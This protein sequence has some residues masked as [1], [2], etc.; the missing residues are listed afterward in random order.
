M[1]DIRALQLATELVYLALGVAAAL[2]AARR[3]EQARVDVALLFGALALLA[4][5]QEVRHASI[6]DAV[7]VSRVAALLVLS[8]PY[9]L[10]RLVDDVREVSPAAPPATLATFALFAVGL[11][12]VPE[13]LPPGFGLAVA[14]FV[15]LGILYAA[16]AFASRARETRGVMCR[17]MWSAAIAA[18]L[19]GAIVPFGLWGVFDPGLASVLNLLAQLVALLSALLFYVAFFPPSVLRRIWRLSELFTYLRGTRWNP[20]TQHLDAETSRRGGSPD[21][22]AL[23]ELCLH[24]AAA[25]GGRRAV[26]AVRD[27]ASGDLFLWGAPSARLSAADGLLGS[28]LRTGKPVFA[29]L[30]DPSQLAPIMRAV[31]P[32]RR[33]PR[34]ALLAPVVVQSEPLGVLAVFGDKRSVFVDDDLDVVAFFSVEVAAILLERQHREAAQEL[35]ALRHADRLKDEFMAVVS[36]E[37]R[38][39]LT[40]ITGYSD[41]LLRKLSGPLNER[42]ERQVSSTRDAARRL[43]ALINDLLD[44]SKLQAGALQLSLQ[45][46]AL[47]DVV[48]RSVAETRAIAATKRIALETTPLEPELPLVMADEQ[49]LQQILVNLI[50]NAVKF[51][52]ERG[53]IVVEAWS[54]HVEAGSHVALAVKDTGMGIAPYDLPRIWE[55]FYQADSSSTREYG[56]AGLGLSIVK[57]LVELHGG[58]VEVTSPGLGQGSTFTVRLPAALPSRAG[59]EM[60]ANPPEPEV[61]ARAAGPREQGEARAERDRPLVL[62]VEDDPDIAAVLRTYLEDDGYS[63]V[64]M[65]DGYR[66]LAFAEAQHPFAIMLDVML[67]RLDGWSVLNRL[68]RNPRTANV[69]VIV[70]SIVDNR[71]YGILLGA[72]DYLVKPVDQERMRQVL[73]RVVDHHPSGPASLL[74]VDDDPAVRAMLADAFADEGWTIRNAPDGRSALQAVEESL[75][76]A[77][78][79]DL[80]M[81]GVDGFEVL[82][83]LRSRKETRDLPVLVLTARELTDDDRSRLAG[84]AQQVVLKQA[85]RIDSLREAIR[86]ALAERRRDI[87]RVDRA[88]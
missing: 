34:T 75:P 12:L 36:H 83:A 6:V 11:L 39:P 13:P 61:V 52:P 5:V 50:A 14:T 4:A 59:G 46:V 62:V 84:A 58:S 67:P 48:V 30:D 78:L 19:L 86:A 21:S 56:G 65:S 45:P 79:L 37:L 10:V 16:W 33:P 66:A 9:L 22:L 25:T 57:R 43:L 51:T 26:L 49:R 3:R 42:Q 68:K 24:V 31:F 53:T 54:E 35:A 7:G 80:M 87:K 63:V 32:D 60:S 38:T 70:V 82:H 85:L 2:V 29:Q 40:A 69:P 76:S 17:R 41:I 20:E 18:T 73:R 47:Q 64:V 71:E 88:A 15:V 55:R 23:D 28:V 81:P 77:V 1:S 8:L 44:V 72:T 27:P 74:I